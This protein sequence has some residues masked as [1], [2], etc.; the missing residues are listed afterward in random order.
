MTAATMLTRQLMDPSDAARARVS[1]ALTALAVLSAVIGL[2]ISR[3]ELDDLGLAGGLHPL[4]WVG[5]VG[6]ALAC[7]VETSRGSAASRRLMMFQIAAW[8]AIVW[9]TPTVLEGTPRFRASYFNY[10]YV[11]PL[12]RGDGFDRTRFLYHNWPLFPLLMAGLR[13]IGLGPE[14]LMAAFPV[15]LT[16]AY[17]ILTGLLL[18]ILTQPSSGAATAPGGDSAGAGGSG[19]RRGDLARSI[20]SL[21]PR[22]LLALFLLPVFNWTGQDYF[23]PQG[24]SFVF[25]LVLLVIVAVATRRREARLTRL[26]TIAV[27]IVFTLIVATHVLTSLFAL[28]VLGVMVVTRQLRPWTIFVTAAVIFFAWQVYIAAPFYA[29]YGDRLV[30]GLLNLDS[31]LEHTV[32]GRVS[33]A[34]GH[35]LVAQLRILA[36]ALVVGLAL[37]AAAMQWA[38]RR[39]D[40]TFAFAIAYLVGVALVIPTSIYGGESLIRGLLFSLPILLV[41]IARAMD[42]RVMRMAV[43]VALL[44]G[45]PLH[46][47]THFGNEEYDYVSKAELE[48]FDKVAT[49]APANIYG[50]YPAG[51]YLETARI[52][53]RNA[54]LPHQDADTT[55]DDFLAPEEHNWADESRPTYVVLTRGDEV[56]VR[57]FRNEPNLIDQVRAALDADP[58]FVVVFRNQDGVIYGRTAPVADTNGDP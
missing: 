29:S 3:L 8:T 4:Y 43:A 17:I 25:F 41:L 39:I 7:I 28:A 48:V 56:A 20:S 45:V 50:G 57:L 46:I 31:F 18:R 19:S 49:L 42:H 40:R 38:R 55:V 10:G 22:L 30:Q 27:L 53:S 33:G 2:V 52:D 36:T 35:A 13:G 11:D 24:L 21:D 47:Y 32:S 1:W 34:P 5:I 16:A 6:L 12:V 9:L 15:V 23:S 26:A 37:L 58:S 51:V 54:S 14:F 44:A